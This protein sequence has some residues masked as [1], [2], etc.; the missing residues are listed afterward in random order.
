LSSTSDLKTLEAFR[1][2]KPV[3]KEAVAALRAAYPELPNDYLAFLYEVGCGQIGN[4]SFMLYSGLVKPEQILGQL[5]QD[6]Q[7]LRIFGDDLQGFCVA[8]DPARSWSLVEIDSN[9]ASL[10]PLALT[11]TEFMHRLASPDH[12]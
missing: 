8:F 10:E 2:L 3:P 9:T 7:G 5:S 11:F 6:L 1:A 12:D 4:G